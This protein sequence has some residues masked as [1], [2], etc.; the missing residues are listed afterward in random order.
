MAVT[1]GTTP[2]VG[3]VWLVGVGLLSAVVAVG[4]V[5]QGLPHH[6]LDLLVYRF[7]S[8]AATHGQALYQLHGPAGLRF[9]YPPF[10]AFAMWPLTLMPMPVAGGV[11]L[12]TNAA[13][14]WGLLALSL[15]HLPGGVGSVRAVALATLLLPLVLLL[16]PVQSTLTF[17]QVNLF[18]ALMV[19]VD[20]LAVPERFRG[21]LTGVAAAIKLTP[22]VYILYLVIRR[23][24][25]SAALA[26]AAAA[27]CTLASFAVDPALSRDFWFHALLD[28]GRIGG[29]DYAGNQSLW[30][31]M[32]R[33]SEPATPPRVLWLALVATVLTV[34]WWVVRHDHA[35]TPLEGYALA[36]VAT[37]LISP[38]SWTHHLTWIV[39][40]LVILG[41]HA[42]RQRGRPG[43]FLWLMGTYLLFTARVPWHFAH[44]PGHHWVDGALG[45]VLE[46]S[47]VLFMIAVLLG[48]TSA[49]RHQ[50]PNVAQSMTA[51]ARLPLQQPPD[52]EPCRPQILTCEY[53]H[54]LISD[55]RL[56]VFT[57][58][59]AMPVAVVA[60]VDGDKSE[61]RCSGTN[62]GRQKGAEVMAPENVLVTIA[63]AVKDE[64]KG[65]RHTRSAL[66]RVTD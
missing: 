58:A 3:G 60:T 36:G 55:H 8:R 47:Y 14:A 23:Q 6:F 29:Q 44:R 11:V 4:L 48:S 19:G 46:S 43:P 56:R 10:A 62:R 22:A 65:K 5:R 64:K 16:E 25:R 13:L 20:L 18:L 24:Y 1:T 61:R 30:G 54:E 63:A 2:R 42:W 57:V 53:G 15:R 34:L 35:V 39:P 51:A 38:I 28:T 66:R 59:A 21:L 31:S 33:L 9:T 37:S 32:F 45:Q 27:A 26:G 49:V 50:H 12:A 40:V 52:A 17:G 7:G 41:G